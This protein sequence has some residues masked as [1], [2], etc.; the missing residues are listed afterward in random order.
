MTTDKS[1]PG[2]KLRML[3]E[4]LRQ[5]LAQHYLDAENR[6]LEVLKQQ[7]GNAPTTKKRGLQSRGGSRRRISRTGNSKRGP[8]KGD[9]L[10]KD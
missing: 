8:R 1:N 9:P 4:R 6:K 5:G 10:I 2:R 3:G 7:K